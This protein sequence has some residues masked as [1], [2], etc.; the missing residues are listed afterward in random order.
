MCDKTQSLYIMKYNIKLKMIT[1]MTQRQLVEFFGM[2]DDCVFCGGCLVTFEMRCSRMRIEAIDNQV[3]YCY[4]AEEQ[5]QLNT[6]I[7]S[8]KSLQKRG[9]KSE[10]NEEA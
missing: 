5:E 4:T 8:I 7:N 2:G 10:G 1:T 6:I 3:Y 9:E